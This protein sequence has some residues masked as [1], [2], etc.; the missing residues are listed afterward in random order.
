MRRLL[1]CGCLILIL[2]LL[3]G[4]CGPAASSSTPRPPDSPAASSQTTDDAY[5]FPFFNP[6]LATVAGSPA[7]ED[8]D[9]GMLRER[10]LDL[11]PEP[12]PEDRPLPAPLRHLKDYRFSLAWQPDPAPLMFLIPGTG[13]NYTSGKTRFLQKTLHDMGFHVI[14]LTSPFNWRF[15]AHGSTTGAPGISEDDARDMLALM[16][17]VYDLVKDRAP[18]TSF[19][20]AGYS[21]G[22]LE[23]AFIAKLD[24]T[25]RRFGFGKVLMINPPVDLWTSTSVFDEYMARHV[26]GRADIF[27]DRLF[28]K[29][30]RYF[31]YRGDVSLDEGFLYGINEISKVTDA[32]LEGVIGSVFRLALANV[33]FSADLRMGGGRILEPGRTLDFGDSTTPYFKKALGLTF[34]EYMEEYLLPLWRDRHPGADRADLIHG[35]GLRSLADWLARAD[36]VFA[37]HNADDI[38]LGPGELDFLRATMGSRLTVWPRGGHLG[39][40]LYRPNVAHFQSLFADALP[41]E[42]RAAGKEARP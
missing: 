9:L 39:N 23:A 34:E 36:H 41:P 42:R 29:V 5:D 10:V 28:I 4:P 33:A 35:I 27:L 2:F 38:I 32:E 37:S 13:S 24:D 22:G 12:G 7:N 1:P 11:E 16:V 21:L 25:E 26:D 14:A 18:A 6:L 19:H 8:M 3:A 40:M 17:R 31:E 15:V 30:S 20:L